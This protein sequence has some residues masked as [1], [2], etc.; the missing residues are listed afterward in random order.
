MPQPTGRS[1]VHVDRALTDLSVKYS[2]SA[3]DFIARKVFRPVPVQFRSD[4]YFVYD[5][6]YW[7][8]SD[9][10]LRAPAT[11]TAGSG[12]KI[13]TDD[14]FCDLVGIHR[15]LD[16]QILSNADSALS[17]ERDAT[18][19]VTQHL[20]QKLEQDFVSTFFTTS[21]W[22]TDKTGGTDF[23]QFDDVASTPIEVIRAE[24]TAMAKLTS[25]K[26]NTLVMGAEVW[27][28]GFADHPDLLDRIKYTQKGVVGPDLLAALLGIDRV[29]IAWNVKNTAAE[30]ATASY[31]FNW[32]KHM[33]L[34]YLPPRPGLNVPAAGYCF[35]WKGLLGSN[36]DGIRIKK[37]R[38]EHLSSDRIEGESAYDLKLVSAD[39]GTFF[40]GAVS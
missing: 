15:D 34:C 28:T 37:F 1:E 36:A 23:T 7:F 22:T 3:D 38:M 39:L 2:Q 33:L 24:I 9:A 12:Y 8:R 14:Y 19:F 30:G 29:L 35:N 18:E 6:S 16:E 40:S 20:L 25:Y 11:E 13:T 31:S 32:G 26:P 10:Q 5:R 21:K 4:K 17:L 27:Q